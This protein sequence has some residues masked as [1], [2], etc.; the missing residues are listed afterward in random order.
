M[1]NLYVHAPVLPIRSTVVS[2]W[3]SVKCMGVV[4]KNDG[5]KEEM[6]QMIE[7]KTDMR[8]KK[9]IQRNG[10]TAKHWHQNVT[11]GFKIV[12]H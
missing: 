11:R 3:R 8:K 7:R 6:R 12:L 2:S 9:K 4:A 1:Y 10:E 5:E